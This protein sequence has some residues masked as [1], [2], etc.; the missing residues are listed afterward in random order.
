V[1]TIH[2]LFIQILITENKKYAQFENF[3]E[4]QK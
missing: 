1:T 4:I 2:F 3:Q